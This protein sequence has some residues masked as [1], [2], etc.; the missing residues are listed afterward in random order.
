MDDNGNQGTTELFYDLG[1]NA[2]DVIAIFSDITQDGKF[3][4]CTYLSPP[5]CLSF[6][7]DYITKSPV[8]LTV[9]LTTGNHIAAL[10]ISDL[11]NPKRL[12][13]PDEEQ[14]TLGPHYIKVTPDQKHLVVT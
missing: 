12:D 1:P 8:L 9:T 5:Y 11:S 10:D 4:Y 2:R 14:P 13:D 6:F 3:A 7:R